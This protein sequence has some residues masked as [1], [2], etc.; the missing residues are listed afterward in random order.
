MGPLGIIAGI[1]LDFVSVLLQC[2][3]VAVR[4]YLTGIVDTVTAGRAAIHLPAVNGIIPITILGAGI[5]PV[6]GGLAYQVAAGISVAVMG[7]IRRT[8]MHFTTST[9]TH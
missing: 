1:I 6:A 3:K 5:T 9:L 7:L 2:A 8:T 4:T